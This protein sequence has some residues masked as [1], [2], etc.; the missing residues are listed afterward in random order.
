MNKLL[1][2]LAFFLGATLFVLGLVRLP[3]GP[4]DYVVTAAGLALLFCSA[5][6][7]RRIS[8]RGNVMNVSYQPPD[9]D[10]VAAKIGEIEA[11]MRRIGMWQDG[12]LAPEQYGFR[13][14]FGMDTMAFEQWLQ[15][16][17]V[18]RVR[19]IIAARGRFPPHSEVAAQ[20][21]REFDAHPLDTSR[22]QTI[23]SEFDRLFGPPRF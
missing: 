17:L 20:A 22:L 10:T 11:E 14:A 23:L 13:Q 6:K 3:G 7:H 16:V 9:Y 5:L 1:L 2:R 4:L 18:P 12:P 8:V 19:E 21:V 15:F